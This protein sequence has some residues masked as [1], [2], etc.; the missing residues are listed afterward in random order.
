MIKVLGEVSVR[1]K[2]IHSITD[3]EVLEKKIVQTLIKNLDS[4]CLHSLTTYL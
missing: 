4:F 1:L 3:D 2:S